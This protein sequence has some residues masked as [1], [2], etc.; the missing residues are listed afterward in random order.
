MNLP[1]KIGAGALVQGSDSELALT[2][3][4]MLDWLSTMGD[5]WLFRVSD[6]GKF[7]W[8]AKVEFRTP[9]GLSAQAKT[10]YSKHHQT[11]N[12]ALRELVEL[13]EKQFPEMLR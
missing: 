5:P 9:N 12:A 8:T 10:T 7:H 4:S 11:P 2:T 3:D 1:E 6:E 13:V